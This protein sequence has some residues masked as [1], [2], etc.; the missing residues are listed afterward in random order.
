[1]QLFGY[2]HMKRLINVWESSL[3]SVEFLFL[4]PLFGVDLS[5]STIGRAII[6]PGPVCA[7]WP[8][9]HTWLIWLKEL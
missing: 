4:R 9:N 3:E 5:G 1:M 8:L 2:N 6:E 7:M